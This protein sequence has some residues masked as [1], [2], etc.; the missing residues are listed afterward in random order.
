VERK[1]KVTIHSAHA[2][3]LMLVFWA[4]SLPLYLCLSLC[5]C[6]SEN[7]PPS[8]F[9]VSWRYGTKKKVIIH[10]VHACAC[11]YVIVTTRLRYFTSKQNR[12][13]NKRSKGLGYYR[14]VE[15]DQYLTHIK[16]YLKT[17]KLVRN[18]FLL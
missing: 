10:S 13:V 5:Q 11:V 12:L 16:R 18:L 7:R 6:H 8:C 4:S 9:T 17:R 15:N 1:N 2:Y 3:V 14:T